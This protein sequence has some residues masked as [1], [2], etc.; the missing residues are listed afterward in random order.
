MSTNLAHGPKERPPRLTALPS[1][2]ARTG[3][4]GQDPAFSAGR[5]SLDGRYAVD[6]ERLVSRQTALPV[7]PDLPGL[8]ARPRVLQ[9][10]DGD[11][12]SHG[13]A[14][15]SARGRAS[16]Q[17]MRA[18]LDRVRT[19][20]MLLDPHARVRCAVSTETAVHH[21]DILAAAR[22]NSFAIRRGLDGADRALIEELADLIG[23]RTIAIHIRRRRPAGHA[24]LVILVGKDKIYA[25]PVRQLRLLG[26][27]TWL[28]V[29]GCLP[30]ASLYRAACAVSFI[31]PCP[32]S[33]NSACRDLEGR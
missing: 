21:L 18:C 26:I 29:P 8:P 9:L 19:A 28:I 4:G 16:D 27:P 32:G 1:G 25:P 17:E 31:G 10:T 2:P 33:P 14:D 12:V 30:A 11:C 3:L 22:N 23:T 20:A 24:D 6:P 13:L 5:G 15:G 7:P